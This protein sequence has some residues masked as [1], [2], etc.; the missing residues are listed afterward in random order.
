[1]VSTPCWLQTYSC[2]AVQTPWFLHPVG[3]KPT[4]VKQF[5]FHGF[6]TL[7]VA[8][9]QLQSNSNSM[10]STPCWLQ[11][12]SCKAVQTPR[13]LHPVGCKPTAVKQFKLHG[14]TPCWLQTYTVKQFK[15][16]GSTP[17]WLQTYS[18]KA[19]QTPR[20]LHPVGCKPTAVKQFKLHGFYT[21]LVAN[22]QL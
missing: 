20:F 22:L 7:L 16:H 8:N 5:K 18:C 17:C 1:M 2:K 13:F 14:S 19:V 4:A 11:T 15:L 6:Y 21:L 9:L 10:V 3:C 12:Y